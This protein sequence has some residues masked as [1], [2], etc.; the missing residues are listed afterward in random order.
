MALLENSLLIIGV[1]MCVLAV[2]PLAF[3]SAQSWTTLKHNRTQ[4]RESQRLLHQQILAANAQ[5]DASNLAAQA[6]AVAPAT[7]PA[8]VPVQA[9][10]APAKVSQTTA[11]DQVA[12]EKSAEVTVQPDGTWRGYRKFRVEKLVE[13]TS[14]CK[15]VYLVP[16]D[17][18]PIASFKA[19][20]HLA[21]RF[22][23]PGQPKPVIRC[24]S[25]SDG[26]GK[27]HYR[28]TVKAIVASQTGQAPGLISNFVNDQ[29]KQGDVI[30]SKAPAGSCCLD[31]CD[32]R[33]VV[34]LAGGIG[35]TPMISII[36]SVQKHSPDR[37]TL[38]L[39][40][41]RN[42]SDLAFVN[43][44]KRME[45]AS[46]NFHVVYCFSA[47]GSE[48]VHGADYQVKGHVSIDLLK[49]LLPHS[50]CRFYLC[51][52]PAFMQSLS[53]GLE[54]WG[55][56]ESQVHSEAFG[57][58]SICKA[59]PEA[60]APRPAGSIEVA[61]EEANQTVK[62]DPNCESLLELAESNG[63]EIDF[64]CRAGSCGTCATELLSGEIRYP[65]DLQVDCE[66]GQCLTCVAR[67]IG[68]IKL[69]AQS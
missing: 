59:R 3:W 66:P 27:S 14:K 6:P 9:Q 40:G 64:G 15:S 25:L 41:V 21:M 46:E 4:F 42:K 39:Y 10:P 2:L 11:A 20:Q 35:V 23:V 43:E 45:Q 63:V 29:L 30:E 8:D 61:F 22:Q 49:Q 44:L 13:E 65:E 1:A 54:S 51:G 68:S 37:P 48:D 55:V 32:P 16:V 62:W 18:K 58:A 17:G 38:L 31:L 50:D 53:E 56:P 7:K 12:A 33:P 69:G 28:I 24:Y 26:P 19:G 34:M 47:P 57:P 52:P 67:P 5:R 60:S 36:D